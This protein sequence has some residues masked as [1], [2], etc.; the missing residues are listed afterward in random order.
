M[1]LN[2]RLAFD[3]VPAN[4]PVNLRLVDDHHGNTLAAYRSLGSPQYLTKEQIRKINAATALP[5]PDRR[6]LN[7]SHLDLDLQ[8]NALALIEMPALP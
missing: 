8:V 1:P 2:V 4:A 7:G 6:H 5:S 3:H